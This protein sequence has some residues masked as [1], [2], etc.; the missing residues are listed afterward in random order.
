MNE[1]A[2]VV[3][4]YPAEPQPRKWAWN[5]QSGKETLLRFT[6][7]R[8]CQALSFDPS[9]KHVPSSLTCV[10]LVNGMNMSLNPSAEASNVCA[11]SFSNLIGPVSKSV[12]RSS[13]RVKHVLAQWKWML[14][15]VDLSVSK[16]VPRCLTC[17]QVFEP[18]LLASAL[19]VN[20]WMYRPWSWERALSRTHTHVEVRSER[21]TKGNEGVRDTDIPR[22]LHKLSHRKIASESLN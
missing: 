16:H 15:Y 18:I 3:T 13:T 5:N 2:A 8:H 12:P 14:G 20:A 22:F 21:D 9:W 6:Q 17:A 19:R 1:I 7:V 10:H 4:S 11:M